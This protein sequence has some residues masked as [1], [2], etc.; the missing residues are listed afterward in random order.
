[1]KLKKN[2]I[3]LEKKNKVNENLIKNI[4]ISLHHADF[5]TN[6]SIGVPRWLPNAMATRCKLCPNV[7]GFLT[8]RHH[9]RVC[10]DIFCSKCCS[11]FDSFQPYYTYN[12]RMCKPC[13]REIKKEKDKDI[14]NKSNKSSNKN[15]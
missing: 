6:E 15:N 10:G 14:D 4:Q 1:M 13:N 7:F 11:I 3:I 12:V 2:R 5:K 9:C 8:R